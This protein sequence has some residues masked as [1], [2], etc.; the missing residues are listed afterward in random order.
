MG[1]QIFTARKGVKV[2]E[3]DQGNT[4]YETRDGKAPLV[5]FMANVRQA[6]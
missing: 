4:Y 1:T 2:G 3:D 5:I 6:G